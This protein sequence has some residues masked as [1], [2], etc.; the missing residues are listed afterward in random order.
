M[1]LQFF[2]IHEVGNLHA[3]NPYLN[4]RVVGDHAVSIPFTVLEMLVRFTLVRRRHP[5]ASGLAV[6]ITGFCA[7]L[8]AHL[9]LHLRPIHATLGAVLGLRTD[10]YA[11]V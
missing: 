3:V 4:V 5:A 1:A 7:I 2:L 10:L 6:N 11:A 8:A 9:N